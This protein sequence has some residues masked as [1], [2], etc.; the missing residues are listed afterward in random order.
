MHRFILLANGG[1]KL[2][3]H[4]GGKVTELK[5]KANAASVTGFLKSIANPQIRG[6]CRAIAG[7][8]ESATKAKPKMWGSS[9]VGFG[10]FR[11]IYPNGREMDWMVTGFSPRKQNITL[12]ILDESKETGELLAELGTHACGKGCLYI[13][14]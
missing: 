12:Y 13:K 11:L 9:I 7:L 10:T 14:R 3:G 2:L 1:A 4:N 8:M 5:T 6:D